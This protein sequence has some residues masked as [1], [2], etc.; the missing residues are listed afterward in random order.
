MKK[1]A[2][3]QGKRHRVSVIKILI[4]FMLLCIVCSLLLN[5]LLYRRIAALNRQIKKLESSS[6]I[7]TEEVSQEVCYEF[8]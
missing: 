2:Q 3:S 7:T 4:A 5:I 8:I 6:T 1:V